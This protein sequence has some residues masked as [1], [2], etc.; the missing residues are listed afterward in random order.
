VAGDPLAPPHRTR[1]AA[2]VSRDPRNPWK[3]I[4]IAL[5]LLLVAVLIAI[6]LVATDVMKLAFSLL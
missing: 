2:V 4:S 5:A 6:A 3:P 1:T